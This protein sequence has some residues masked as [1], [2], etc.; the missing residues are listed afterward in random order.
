MNERKGVVFSIHED[1]LPVEAV[2]FLRKSSMSPTIIC[3]TF[4]WPLIRISVLK[5]IRKP[6]S[7]MFFPEACLCIGRSVIG[8]SL[9]GR[10]W[11]YRL[12]K[13]SV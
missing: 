10:S 11:L 9:P 13:P 3:F 4:L 12:V 5:R 2:R 1:N 8:K 6:R 7:F